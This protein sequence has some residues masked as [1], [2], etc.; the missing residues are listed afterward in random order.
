M[1]KPSAPSH[2]QESE[3]Q[4]AQK[5]QQ[6]SMN[7]KS[8]TY[9]ELYGEMNLF[10]GEWKDGVCAII[11]KICVADTTPDMK[12]ILFD[13]PVDTLWIESM[14]SVLDDSKLLCLDNGVRIKLP[15]TVRMMFEVRRHGPSPHHMHCR[16][17][18][19]FLFVGRCVLVPLQR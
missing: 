1:P 5:V 10:T 14:N 15:D 3:N 12:W 19:L 8:I 17:A 4:F 13:G 11:A 7:P 16:C 18:S 6:Y 9:G 2:S